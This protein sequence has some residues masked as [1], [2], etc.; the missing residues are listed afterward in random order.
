[1]KGGGGRGATRDYGTSDHRIESSGYFTQTL[2]VRD[3]LVM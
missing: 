1:M 3:V 2:A